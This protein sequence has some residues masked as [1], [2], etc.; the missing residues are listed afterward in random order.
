MSN[1][2]KS[3]YSIKKKN[4]YKEIKILGLKIKRGN[5]NNQQLQKMENRLERIEKYVELIN[6]SVNTIFRYQ[7]G[8]QINDGLNKVG[9]TMERIIIFNPEDA[10]KDHFERYA[11]ASKYCEGKKVVDVACGCGYGSNLLS[12]KAV[13]VLGVDLC[14]GAVDFANRFFAGDNCHFVCQNA[15]ELKLENNFDRAVS[16]ETIEHIENPKPLLQSLCQLLNKDGLLICS[17]PNQNI[18]PFDKEVSIHHFRH[19][20]P[21]EFRN[22]LEECGFEI[23]DSLYQYYGD[24]S[25]KKIENLE[26]PDIVLIAKKK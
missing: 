12:R 21:Q 23:V 24:Y 10:P 25:V 8:L 13:N 16:F 26:G 11:F 2:L 5:K 20:T 7:S 15:C 1:I 19:Y 4:G 14:Q 17:V 3:L 22:L 6:K 18:I 9:T